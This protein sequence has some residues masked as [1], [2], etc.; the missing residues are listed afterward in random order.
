MMHARSLRRFLRNVPFA[1]WA[2]GS[3]RPRD[4][5]LRALPRGSVGMEIGV[6]HGDFSRQL[7]D[8]VSPRELHLVDPWE[9]STDPAYAQAWYGGAA[10][11]GAAEMDAR[12]AAVKA[13]FA[14]AIAAGIVTVHRS[15]SS[16]ALASFPD[17]YFDWI[18]IDGN[19]TYEFVRQDL[20]LSDRKVKPGGLIAGDDYGYAGWWEDG[21]TRAVD[22]FVRERAIQ[23]FRLMRDQFL[24]R[25]N[26]P[27]T[28]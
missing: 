17:G 21:V 28:G 13:R 25:K 15:Y 24:I 27:A 10:K 3:Q 14:A 6:H 1:G 12:F 4:E 23:D 16:D 26:V 11:G 9:H 22:E 18:Y 19:H 5:L 20:E 2:I 7:L 8:S